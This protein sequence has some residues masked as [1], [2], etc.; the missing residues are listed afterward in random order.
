[1]IRPHIM[2]VEA[3]HTNNTIKQPPSPPKQLLPLLRKLAKDM[4]DLSLFRNPQFVAICLTTLCFN[5]G[6]SIFYQHTPSR[7][8]SFGVEKTLSYYITTVVGIVTLFARVL[9]AVI[10]NMA[11]TD[12][13]VEYGVSVVMGGLCMGLTGMAQDY[14]GICIIAA[15]TGFCAGQLPFITLHLPIVVLK[16][17]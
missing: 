8:V 10:G 6:A 1:M 3:V 2:T 12:R 14:L 11:C 13:V 17:L 16:Y 9:G 15:L 7:A 5:F 4:T